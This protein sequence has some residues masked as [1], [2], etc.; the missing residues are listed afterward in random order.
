MYM[1]DL[2]VAFLEKDKTP[3]KSRYTQAQKNAIY[4]FREKTRDEYNQYQREYHAERMRTDLD[5]RNRR[6]ENS[7]R[8]HAKRA[9]KKRVAELAKVILT[10]EE[11]NEKIQLK[12][13]SQII[14]SS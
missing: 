2:L 13:N 7:R 1:D 5:Y 4:K 12:L 6:A 10:N 9:E 14:L 3:K 11:K 8:A